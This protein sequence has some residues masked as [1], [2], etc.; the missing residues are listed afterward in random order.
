MQETFSRQKLVLGFMVFF[1]FFYG[2]L[3]FTTIAFLPTFGV[4]SALALSSTEAAELMAYYLGPLLVMRI[5]AIFLVS[6]FPCLINL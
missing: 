5:V 6:V 1:F 2:C 4:K 3:E